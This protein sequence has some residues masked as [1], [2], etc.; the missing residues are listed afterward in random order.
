M[1]TLNLKELARLGAK[2]RL[3][4]L[5]AEETM[6]RKFIGGTTTTPT[7]AVVHDTGG[8]RRHMSAAARKKVSERMKAMWAERKAAGASRTRTVSTKRGTP[9]LPA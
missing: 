3:T 2:S 9:A 1:N 7:K 8:P 6:L 5:Q 4:E